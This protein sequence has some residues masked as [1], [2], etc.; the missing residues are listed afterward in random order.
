MMAGARATVKR[1]ERGV[2]VESFALLD[3]SPLRPK[4]EP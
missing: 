1:V 4:E 3:P 2:V